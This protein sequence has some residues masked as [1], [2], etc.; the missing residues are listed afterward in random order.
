MK[1]QHAHVDDA[2]VNVLPADEARETLTQYESEHSAG[3]STS[4]RLKRAAENEDF[5]QPLSG[6]GI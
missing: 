4:R 2:Y 3:V 6:K 1:S 5:G